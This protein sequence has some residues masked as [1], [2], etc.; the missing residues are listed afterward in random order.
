MLR[1]LK[2]ELELLFA[3]CKQMA[4]HMIQDA[5][6]LFPTLPDAVSHHVGAN[7]VPSFRIVAG[8]F[9]LPVSIPGA[10]LIAIPSN[11]FE[12]PNPYSV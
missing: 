12:F 1:K 6:N 10:F 9:Q 5:L 3:M 11:I 7:H 2:G 8:A 4:Q